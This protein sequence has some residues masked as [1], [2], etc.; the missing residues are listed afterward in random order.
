MNH[1]RPAGSYGHS[2]TVPLR[3]LR[4]QA[5]VCARRSQPEMPLLQPSEPDPPIGRRH[6]GAGFLRVFC[7]GHGTGG[8]PG[9]ADGQ[10]PVLRRQ[11]YP[12]TDYLHE[13]LPLLRC[14]AAGPGQA[15]RLIKPGAIL[16]FKIPRNK[17]LQLFRDWLG[18]LWFAP[19][20]SQG[21]GRQGRR[22]QGDVHPLL[23]L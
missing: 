3:L 22:H 21:T 5:R 8:H 20:G 18:S 13:S 16:P 17:A 7:P 23:D 2:Q 14:P 1:H 4:C 15:Q 10:V 12:A 19:G 9:G 6:P 11:L